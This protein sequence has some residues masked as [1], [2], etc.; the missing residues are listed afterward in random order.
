[1]VWRSLTLVAILIL[2]YFLAS[3]QTCPTSGT[4]NLASN[5]NTYY[6]GTGTVNV[7]ATQITLGSIAIGSTPIAAGD[8]VLIIQIQGAEITATNNN[9]YGN[10]AVGAPASGYLNNANHLAGNME[11]AVVSNVAGNVITLSAGTVRAYRDADFGSFGQYRFQVIRV[12]IYYDLTLTGNIFT[13][14]WNGGAGGVTVLRVVNNLNMG[15][16]TINASA[17]G[18]RGGGSRQLGGGAGNS[19]DVRTQSTENNNGSKGEGTAGTPRYMFINTAVGDNTV[20]GYPN[21]SHGRGAPGNAGGGATDGNPSANDENTGGGGGGNGG[22]GGRGGDAWNSGLATGGDGG[23]TFAQLAANRVVMGGGGGGGTTNNG[24]G[25]PGSG[26][27]TSGAAGGGIVILSAKFIIAAGTINVNGQSANNT[28]TN[29]GSGGGGAGGSALLTAQSGLSNITVLANGGNGGSNS[30]GGVTHGPGGGG[31]GGVVYSVAPLNTS[32]S[33][34][35]GIAGT[36][37]GGI[38]YG[39]TDGTIGVLIQNALL[40]SFPNNAN[41]CVLLPALM[42]DFSLQ[43]INTGLNLRWTVATEVNVKEYV[44]EKS[45]DG[46][47]FQPIGIVPFRPGSGLKQYNFLDPD[48]SSAYY[49]IRTVDIDARFEYSKVLLHRASNRVNG[50]FA[51]YPNPGRDFF[52]LMLP[53]N[54]NRTITVKLTDMTGRLVYSRTDRSTGGQYRISIPVSLKGMYL[55]LVETDGQRYQEKVM[56]VD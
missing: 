29:D 2:S 45:I 11:Y 51:V 40:T 47:L 1:M 27:A 12:P 13:P 39:A 4:T 49:R 19:S 37:A 24:T 44:V 18:F 14:A 17:A 43:E 16:F 41:L 26:A 32:S 8:L 52:Q 56:I 46:I 22:T 53:G 42:T 35:P 48:R 7:G 5:P 21:G 50:G 6:P 30:G 33:V 38:N 10:N 9:R 36:T 3:S 34:A 28:V 54:G 25:T 23:V 15:G 55:L 31:G 20:E